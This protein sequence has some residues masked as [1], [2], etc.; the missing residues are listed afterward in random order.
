MQ[1]RTKHFATGAIMGSDDRSARGRE[2]QERMRPGM[3]KHL[4]D[5]YRGASADFGR[6]TT[7]ILFGE[8]W[9]RD[10]LDI[11]SRELVTLGVLLGAGQLNDFRIH[12]GIAT[13]LGLTRAEIVEIVYHCAPY[14]GWPRAGDGFAIIEEVLPQDG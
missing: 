3:S 12:V 1:I 9:Q 14:V 10:G 2:L 6:Y 4:E 7:E 11:R 8:F 5:R 13:N